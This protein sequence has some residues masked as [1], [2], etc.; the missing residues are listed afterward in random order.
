VRRRKAALR[1]SV[2]AVNA[3]AR[4]TDPDERRQD[5]HDRAIQLEGALDALAPAAIDAAMIPFEA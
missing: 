5:D 4:W 3:P 1:A 2:A